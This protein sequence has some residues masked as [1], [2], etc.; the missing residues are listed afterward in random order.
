MSVG[1]EHLNFSQW[2]TYD[3][4]QQIGR[5]GAMAEEVGAGEMP[6]PIYAA[7]HPEA[8]LPVEDRDSLVAWAEHMREF[9]IDQDRAQR[10]SSVTSD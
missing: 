2:A 7:M 8:K 1:R 5:L 3:R 9:L 4:R 10:D 6:L